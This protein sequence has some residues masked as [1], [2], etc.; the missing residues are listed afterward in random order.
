MNATPPELA[1]IAGALAAI[2]KVLAS[3]GHGLPEVP[4]FGNTAL[5]AL[6]PDARDAALREEEVS[7]RARPRESAIHFCLTS[8][9]ALLD[10]SQTLLRQ[11]PNPSPQDQAREWKALISHTK[12]AGRAAYRAALILADPGGAEADGP[13]A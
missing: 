6:P 9:S 2:E 10:V 4:F 5:G 12:V 11:P 13:T 7:Y 3:A 1:L 8:A